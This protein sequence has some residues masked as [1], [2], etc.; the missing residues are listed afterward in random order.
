M[1]ESTVVNIDKLSSL[2]KLFKRSRPLT[3]YKN[4]T[5]EELRAKI[6]AKYIDINNEVSKDEDLDIEDMFVDKDEKK[7][8]KKLIKK[9]LST[10]TIET[11]SDKN[12]LKQLV[13]L[14]V[15]NTR[16]EKELNTYHKDGQPSPTKTV[17][18][19]HSNLN[20]ISTLKD[21]LGLS[22]DKRAENVNDGYSVLNTLFKKHKIWREENQGSRNANCP[23]CSKMILF[24]IRTDVWEAQK[25]PFF[26]DK[27]LVNDHLMAMYKDNK[28]SK[29]DVAR[30]L[31]TSLDYISWLVKKIYFK[32]FNIPTKVEEI[33]EILV[34]ENKSEE[35]KELILKA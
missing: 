30:V 12:T 23:Y 24:K 17:D 4:L 13:F 25:H 31:G 2:D 29:H 9:Y 27:V 16:L 11:I 34:E 22:R 18:A 26:R 14:E 20:Q 1:S 15:F 3:Q 5:D 7:L 10:Y 28:I 8:A 33:E 21:K 6:K 19:L 35:I 32:E